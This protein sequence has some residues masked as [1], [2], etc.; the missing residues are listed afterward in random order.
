MSGTPSGR[1]AEPAQAA[2][3]WRQTVDVELPP[4]LRAALEAFS[5][6]GFHGTSV[7]DIARRVGV[8]VPSLYYHHANK[9][10]I[11]V[12]LLHQSL[13]RVDKV[14]SAAIAEAGDG[15]HHRFFAIVEGLLLVI[16]RAGPMAM[17]HYEIR[18][19][20]EPARSAYVARRRRFESV[21]TNAIEEAAE[22]QLFDVTHP[23][24]AARAFLGMAQAIPVWY[25]PGRG[26][27]TPEDV[28]ERYLDLAAHLVGASPAVIA[29]VRSGSPGRRPAGSPA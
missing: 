12:D 2:D 29:A 3:D 6:Q 7:R 17:M 27:L 19:L 22:A 20:T 16:C 10:A 26:E 5:T 13:D 15:P 14:C 11:L 4:I 8:T 18:A 9:E 23:A 1:E 25:S 21:L 24:E 28:T